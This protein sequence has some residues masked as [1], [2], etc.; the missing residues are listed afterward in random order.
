[1][2]HKRPQFIADLELQLES[3]AIGG[4]KFSSQIASA[5]TD[6]TKTRG[7]DVITYLL[8]RQK[9]TYY[10]ELLN[11]R[12][13]PDRVAGKLQAVDD[14]FTTIQGTINDEIDRINFEESQ[15]AEYEP[16]VYSPFTT[17]NIETL[18]DD[19]DA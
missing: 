10:E 14:F 4:D 1:M 15:R 2:R 11:E 5:L 8:Q 13:D 6:F 17:G 16:P 12:N 9:E 19:D 3:R 18:E 7:F